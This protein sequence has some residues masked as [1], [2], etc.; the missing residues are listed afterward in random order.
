MPVQF[1][2]SEQDGLQD[3][4]AP[5]GF[6]VPLGV[7]VLEG[8]PVGR[9]FIE[10]GALGIADAGSKIGSPT[11][12]IGVLA[13]AVDKTDG[14]IPQIVRT[15]AGN[16]SVAELSQWESRRESRTNSPSFVL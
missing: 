4:D 10:G 1:D 8:E 13:Y 12:G 6:R 2:E 15:G 14:I 7:G 3:V 16:Q 11:S 5:L 9:L